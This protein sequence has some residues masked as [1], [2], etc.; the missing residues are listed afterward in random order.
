MVERSS[1]SEKIKN[2]P[3]QIKSILHDAA[4]TCRNDNSLFQD[5]GAALH[6]WA[7]DAERDRMVYAQQQQILQQQR[8][9]YEM[10][11][12]LKRMLA[13]A[14]N[15]MPSHYDFWGNI[16]PHSIH[17]S[18]SYGVYSFRLIHS[19][20]AHD[21]P[22]HFQQTAIELQQ[23]LDDIYQ[24]ALT[25]LSEKYWG[26]S[27]E[28]FQQCLSQMLWGVSPQKSIND[29]WNDYRVAYLANRCYLFI[30][31]GV[32]MTPVNDGVCVSFTANYD[33]RGF[34]PAKYLSYLESI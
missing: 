26:D 23:I 34:T 22:L 8:Q 6:N 29:F 33:D 12:A 30:I 16:S 28:Y 10:S 21:M 18:Y 14:L 20:D 19:Q 17:L 1:T 7:K 3:S 25:V 31:A 15:C 5:L 9:F 27:D 13:Y 32:T 4:E 24:Y 11:A 2:L